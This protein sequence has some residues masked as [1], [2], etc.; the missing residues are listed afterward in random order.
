MSG[1]ARKA[2]GVAAGDAETA[3]LRDAVAALQSSRDDDVAL[4]AAMVE[5][6]GER[7]TATPAAVPAA[8]RH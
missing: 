6:L 1:W 5:L 3:R 4:K 7:A 2:A 8:L